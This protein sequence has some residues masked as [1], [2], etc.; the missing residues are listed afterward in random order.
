ME[1][2]SH[3]QNKDDNNNISTNTKNTRDFINMLANQ[4]N[5]LNNNK[6]DI[7]L[8]QHPN[9]DFPL[10]Y[11]TDDSFNNTYNKNNYFNNNNIENSSVFNLNNINFNNGLNSQNYDD[12]I[13]NYYNNIDSNINPENNNKLLSKFKHE[14]NK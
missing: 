7:F 14:S 9:N 2:G 12:N 5:N 8:S 4:S 11:S 10:K 1:K 13:N 3:Q 6:N